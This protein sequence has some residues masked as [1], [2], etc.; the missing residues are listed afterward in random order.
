MTSTLAMAAA[1]IF[2]HEEASFPACEL[3]GTQAV[4]DVCPSHSL[5]R[6]GD[7]C[8]R[9]PASLKAGVEL[10]GAAVHVDSEVLMHRAEHKPAENPTTVLGK[11]LVFSI[12]HPVLHLHYEAKLSN[13]DI[14][15]SQVIL[16]ES[17]RRTSGSGSRQRGV[18]SG[19]GH[20]VGW[21]P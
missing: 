6:S 16:T 10:R 5:S 21:R 19:S 17:L 20:R 1:Q 13:T 9:V 12:L 2:R 4:C 14:F 7:V 11:L 15:S 3:A 18:L 8:V